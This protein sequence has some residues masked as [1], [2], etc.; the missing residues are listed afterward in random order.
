MCVCVCNAFRGYACAC[1]RRG[2][3]VTGGPCAA[4]AMTHAG[5][6]ASSG[7]TQCPRPSSGHPSQTPSPSPKTAAAVTGGLSWLAL[8]G[9]AESRRTAETRDKT[10]LPLR[11]HPR[12]R[13]TAAQPERILSTHMIPSVLLSTVGA[14]V[15]QQH[16]LIAH[17]RV[18]P[19]GRARVCS[20]VAKRTHLR[21]ADSGARRVAHT[22]IHLSI[23][24]SIYV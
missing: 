14:S 20:G 18:R 10:A 8:L 12:F 15:R 23:Y 3:G 4:A 21:V 1:A 16:N 19:G 22:S 2:R 13:P 5:R 17:A 6:T 7:P 9:P 24:L 11:S